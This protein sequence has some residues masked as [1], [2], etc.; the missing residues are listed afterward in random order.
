MM[1]K[2]QTLLK[3]E[4]GNVIVIFAF[5]ILALL[6]VTAMVID[7]GRLYHEK[8]VLQNALDAAVLGG[9]HAL[10]TSEVQAASVAKD[11]ASKNSFSIDDSNL[12]FTSDSIKATKEVTVPLT[13]AKAIGIPEAKV[14]ATAKAKITLLKAAKGI[15]PIAIEESSLPYGTELKC[16]NTGVHH[17]NCGYLDINGSGANGLVDGILN[18]SEIAEG[19]EYVDTEPGEKWGPVKAAFETLISND[20]SKSHC[21]SP[22]TADNSCDRIIFVTVI[23]TWDDIDGKGTVKVVGLAAYWIQEIREPKRIIGQFV[24]TITYGEAGGSGE[25]NLYGVALVE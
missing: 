15:T 11:I 23:E 2:V 12:T 20:A 6:G 8:S 16:S 3:N 17:G 9:A 14:S 5:A 22:D 24:P 18:G 25:G 13:F 21:Q 1:K 19:A 10:K 4:N 7:V